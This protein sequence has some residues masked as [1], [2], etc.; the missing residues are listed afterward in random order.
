MH[1]LRNIQEIFAGD[2][3]LLLDSS[4]HMP[5]IRPRRGAERGSVGQRDARRVAEGVWA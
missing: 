1:H 2:W 5:E 4:E 3:R